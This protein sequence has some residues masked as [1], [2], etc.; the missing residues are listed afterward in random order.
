MTEYAKTVKK[1][2]IDIDKSQAW[3]IEEVRNRTGLYVDTSYLARIFNGKDNGKK[4]IS[5]IN[6]ILFGEQS[7]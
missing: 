6:E 4:V 5:A 7:E 1:K 2:L 3:L